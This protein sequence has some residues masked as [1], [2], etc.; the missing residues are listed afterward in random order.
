MTELKVD[1]YKEIRCF[2]IIS[3]KRDKRFGLKCNRLLLKTNSKG[4]VAGQIKCPRCGALYEI[5]DGK[6]RLIKR[7]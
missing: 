3:D 1:E 6:I 5:I 4:R 7:R 2:N